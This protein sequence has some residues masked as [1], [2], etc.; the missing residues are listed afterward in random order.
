MQGPRILG[1]R[2]DLVCHGALGRQTA[3]WGSTG[4]LLAQVIG[5]K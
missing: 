2:G 3:V 5:M 1:C 4:L